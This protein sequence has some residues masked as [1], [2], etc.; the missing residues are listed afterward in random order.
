MSAPVSNLLNRLDGVKEMSRGRWVAKCPAHSDKRPSLSIREGD[1]GAVLVKCW[2][3]CTVAE[4]ASK[5]GLELTDLF[6]PRAIDSA[7]RP[8]RRERVIT[9]ADGLRL[10]DYEADVICI[11][12]DMIE[13]G[14]PLD[15]A[16]RDALVTAR[17]TIRNVYR[18]ALA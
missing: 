2:A 7:S 9:A 1:T 6:P 8:H 14:K 18:E 11:V 13:K 16:T 10:L 17:H 5:A 15:Q 12:A 3:G 4:I